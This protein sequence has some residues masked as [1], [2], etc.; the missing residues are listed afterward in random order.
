MVVAK[1]PRAITFMYLVC[2]FSVILFLG[3]SG[4]KVWSLCRAADNTGKPVSSLVETRNVTVKGLTEYEL[5]TRLRAV[6][7][8]D[9][10]GFRAIASNF[11]R[12]VG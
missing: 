5:R 7:Q 4:V 8:A 6:D 1:K 11:P 9:M 2:F 12:P 3:A 10:I